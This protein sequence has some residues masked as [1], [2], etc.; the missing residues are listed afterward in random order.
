MTLP[1]MYFSVFHLEPYPYPYPNLHLLFVPTLVSVKLHEAVCVLVRNIKWF[2]TEDTRVLTVRLGPNS[3]VETSD[4]T[5]PFT[6]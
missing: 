2:Q 3:F 4:S 6:R 5:I 1:D